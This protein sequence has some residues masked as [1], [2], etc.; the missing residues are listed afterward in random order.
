MQRRTVSIDLAPIK[1]YGEQNKDPNIQ[2]VPNI[3]FDNK[4]ANIE[5]MDTNNLR[6]NKHC[7]Y[8]TNQNNYNNHNNH[9]NYNNY[10]NHN[11]HNNYN[12]HQKKNSELEKNEENIQNSKVKSDIHLPRIIKVIYLM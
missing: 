11:N 2:N 5:K 3:D 8:N 6:N 10:N 9:N 12:N 4:K 1:I 7:N